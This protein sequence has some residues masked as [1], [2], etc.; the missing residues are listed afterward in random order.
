MQSL[1][2]LA[3]SGRQPRISRLLAVL[4]IGAT[5][6]AQAAYQQT[7]LVTDDQ[8]ALAA[9][10]FG[11]ALTV[12]PDLINPWGISLSPTG[13]PLWVSNQGSSTSTLYNGAGQKQGLVVDIPSNGPPAG[14]TGQVFN[15]GN[16]FTLSNGT[17]GF[18][19]FANLDGTV[20]GWNPGSTSAERVITAPQAVYTGIALGSSSGS[21]FMYLANN[22]AGRIDVF[23]EN[24]AAATLTGSFIDP[25]LP[26]GLAPFNVQNIG[27]ELYVTYAIP[28]PDA[29]EVDLGSGVVDVFDTNGNFIR[30]VAS[31]GALASPWGLALAP[32]DFG[33]F[34]N[35]LL[36]GNFNDE[37]GIINAFDPISGSFLGTLT[38]VN[39]NAIAI[40]DLWGLSFGN[41]GNGGPTNALF[42][43]AGIGDELHGLFGRL[44][45]AVAAVP[46]PDIALL[47][48][49]A[50][51]GVL[52]CRGPKRRPRSP[53]RL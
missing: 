17:K 5:C 27:G 8:D 3:R 51:T 28:G 29:D 2:Q 44:D 48:L 35:A 46:E 32:S 10:G 38:D 36:V 30:R 26:A 47:V 53:R 9:E 23:D 41:G 21:D 42:F 1:E 43:A 49:S 7:N 40:P 39:D 45:V 24:F 37:H 20:S 15:A 16:D 12:D 13:S 50:L 19:F 14:P 34:S 6:G 52:M 11:P 31:G 33:T 4:L 22:A 18:F 25:N